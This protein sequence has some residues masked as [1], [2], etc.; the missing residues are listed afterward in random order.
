MFLFEIFCPPCLFSFRRPCLCDMQATFSSV[1]FRRKITEE[2]PLDFPSRVAGPLLVQMA[3]KSTEM[4]RKFKLKNV[5]R[6]G[7]VIYYAEWQCTNVCADSASSMRASGNNISSSSSMHLQ[8]IQI[9]AASMR[10]ARTLQNI[11]LI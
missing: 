7:P 1:I 5:Q 4:D 2:I 10:N 8:A 6:S 3:Q 9:Y 11:R